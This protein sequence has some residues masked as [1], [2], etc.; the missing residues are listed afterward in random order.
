MEL[1]RLAHQCHW[2][3]QREPAT[4]E[5]GKH[6]SKSHAW[7]LDAQRSCR[8]DFFRSLS[9][10]AGIV[11]EAAHAVVTRGSAYDAAKSLWL[12]SETLDYEFLSPRQMKDTFADHMASDSCH[13]RS[14]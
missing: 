5:K 3:Y 4:L 7:L 8:M 14:L 10:K 11:A 13:G 9:A 6:A 1:S 2:H 12:I